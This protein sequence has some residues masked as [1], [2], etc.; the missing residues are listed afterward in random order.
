MKKNWLHISLIVF[1]SIVV[2][3]IVTFSDNF[4]TNVYLPVR[5][6]VQNPDYAISSVSD[7][8]VIVGIQGEGWVLSSYYWGANKYFDYTIRGNKKEILVPTRDLIKQEH[9]FTSTVNIVNISPELLKITLDKKLKKEVFVKPNYKLSLD[10]NYGLIDKPKIEPIKLTIFGPAS[11]VSKIDTIFTEQISVNHAT[12]SMRINSEINLPKYVTAN[13]S[14]VVVEF[15]IQKIVDKQVV[16]VPI[17]IIGN[18]DRNKKLLI[19][20]DKI[21]VTVRG[22]IDIVGRINASDITAFISFKEAL[23]DTTASLVP[24]IRLTKGVKLVTFAPGKIDYIIKK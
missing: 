11:I 2:W 4:Y 23:A 12:D 21:N 8:F 20:P 6:H 3:T 24:H 18:T 15:D 19:F 13:I 9:I 10:D 1:F 16:N 22:G 5:I 17:K 14:N 7:K